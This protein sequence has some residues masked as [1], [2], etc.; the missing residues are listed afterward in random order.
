MVQVRIIK[1]ANA[2][3]LETLNRLMGQMSLGPTRPKPLT[4]AILKSLLAQKNIHLLA[5]VA[6]SAGKKKILGLLTVYFVHIPSGLTCIAEDLIIDEPYRKWGIGR[7]LME[8]GIE[9]AREK[10]A[11]HISL[12]TNP[13]RIEANKLYQAL[14]FQ[15]METN[16]YRINLFK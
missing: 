9:L 3:L 11:R 10:R 12:R 1:K 13:K 8:R 6:D 4:S 7:I 2:D 16:F 14:G 15:K 5:A